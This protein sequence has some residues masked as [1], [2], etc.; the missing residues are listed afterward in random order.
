MT[1]SIELRGVRTHN[2]KNIDLT[3]PRNRIVVITGVSGSGKSSLAFDT[4]FAEGQRRYVESLSAY[5]RQFL[6]V[7]D[8]PELDYF[9]GVSPSIAI[10]QKA[11]SHN[12]RSTVG[13]ATEIQDYLRLLY[14]RVG[15]ARCPK[16]DIELRAQST[17][18]M[19]RQIVQ[20]PRDKVY[21]LLAVLHSE[22]KGEYQREFQS[23]AQRGFA[24][25]MINQEIYELDNPPK[26]DRRFKNNIEVV[27]YRFRVRDDNLSTLTDSLETAV[28]ISNGLVRVVTMDKEEVLLLSSTHACPHCQ[29][30]VPELEPRLF[31]FNSPVGA[32]G[33]CDGLGMGEHI[34]PDRLILHP[35]LS[36]RQG[37]IR[38]WGERNGFYFS[39]LEQMAHRFEFSLDLPWKQLD[40]SMQKL[41]LYGPPE[42]VEKT[43]TRRRSRWHSRRRGLAG[44]DGV[45]NYL[46][47]SLQNSPSQS[48]LD[49][50]SEFLE[51]TVCRACQGSRLNA[52]ANCIYLDDKR[53][54]DLCQMPIEELQTALW[55]LNIRGA[56]KEISR[57][58][59]QEIARRLEF[60][61]T[62]GLGYLSLARSSNTLSGGESQRIRLASQIGAGLVGV[63][64]VLDEPSIGLHQKDTRRLLETLKALRDMD[65]T[66][67]IVEHDE[68]IINSA[69]HVVDI[70]P[71]AGQLG[72]Y[73]VAAGTPEFIAAHETSLT[74]HFLSG[75][76]SI[77]IPRGR[78]ALKFDDAIEIS[79]ARLNN[80]K[81][82]SVVFPVGALTCV[83]GVSGSGKSTLVNETLCRMAMHHLHR[84]TSCLPDS[85]EIAHIEKI[86]KAIVI[87]QSPIGR[88]PRSN[89]ATYTGLFTPIRELFAATQ[90]ARARGY[91]PGRFSFNVAGG[92]CEKC[93]GDGSIRVEMHF[94]SDMYVQC[95]ACNG[96]R[97]NAETLEVRFKKF[98]ILE[99]LN[100]T[101]DEAIEVFP[102]ITTVAEKLKTLQHVGLGYIRLG[103]SATTLSGGEAQ[104]IKLSRELSK[105]DTGSTLYILDEPTVGLHFQD[106]DN[107]IHVLARLRD[108]GNTLVVIEH[109]LDVIKNAD[110]VIDLGPGGGAN[111][112]HILC[113]GTPEEVAKC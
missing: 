41:V 49:S 113:S 4:I 107:L 88:T 98:N 26:L 95:D 92:V 42:G 73:V 8:K 103:Q 37:V 53:L 79:H 97:Y 96:R 44:F 24:R 65:N 51:Q 48:F 33:E 43:R 6:N 108:R 104:R 66:I 21:M 64:Y 60:L 47:S 31:S 61:V 12:P 14:A 5:A 34:N 80:L 91:K 16:H 55:A 69:D 22:R 82:L 32:C 27:V 40:K 86:D 101:V 35:G 75:H 99:V 90:D 17:D 10:D 45:V 106:V 85:G 23:L 50:A 1:K 2:L 78:G 110:W 72:G 20:L 109:N 87:D 111:G 89:P 39:L 102:A 15:V 56:E 81:D 112:G 84:S 58:I 93:K 25:V 13:T 67:I 19:I 105:R 11:S 46:N 70:G 68:E 7:A 38:G 74:G 94:L 28:S 54:N 30:T 71:G 76:K 63:M 100:M 36:L 9:S 18:E 57:R 59:L 3:L 29:F 62:V 77:A 83:T 52:V